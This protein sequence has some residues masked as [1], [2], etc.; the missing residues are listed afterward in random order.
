MVRITEELIRKRAEHNEGEIFSLEELSLHQQNLERIE[1]LDRWCRDLKIL[2][3]QNNLIPK[4]EHV[5][6]LKKLEYFNLALNNVEK[7]E[8]LE[9]CES[10]KKLD[11]T[12][13]FVGELTSIESL[14]DLYA[15]EEL[16]LTGNPCAEY[17]HYRDFVI[18]TLPQLQK[19]DGVE[20]TKSERI[21]ALQKLEQIRPE[22][23]KCQEKHLAKRVEEKLAA[24]ARRNEHESK[25]AECS[26]DIDPVVQE[27][28]REKV[29]F[30][31]ESRVETHEYIQLQE[32][33]KTKPT[34][35]KP[36][37]KPPR[38]FAD[39]G[40]PFN[41]NEPKVQFSLTE[42][43]V[44]GEDVFLLDVHVY[45]YMDSSLVDCDVQTNYVRVILRGKV[46]QLALPED[47]QPDRSEAKRSQTTGNLTVTMPKAVQILGARRPN[48]GVNNDKL[49]LTSKLRKVP[50]DELAPSQKGTSKTLLELENAQPLVPK[51]KSIVQPVS[52]AQPKPEEERIPKHWPCC[53]RPNSPGFVDCPDVPPLI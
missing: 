2:Y 5:S 52:T 44:N 32:K 50:V 15:L 24:E 29:P 37:R 12:V 49:T 33:A 25:L 40:R 23:L 22:I 45:R 28:W 36:K 3:L 42:Q 11:L 27:F 4:I 30:T 1:H 39:N 6:R 8:N 43:Q 16:Y 19:L 7:I 26:G 9:G 31:P 35:E 51:W 38:L 48:N 20:I 46:L 17:P 14:V 47:V 34:E 21:I 53:S 10:L 41:I 18:A 13:N